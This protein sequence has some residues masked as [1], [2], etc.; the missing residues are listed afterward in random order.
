LS[1]VAQILF[2]FC[3]KLCKSLKTKKRRFIC[4]L[5]L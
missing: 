5:R 3:L 2:S 4:S 1:S